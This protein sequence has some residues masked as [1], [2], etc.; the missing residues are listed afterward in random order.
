MTVHLGLV[1]KFSSHTVDPVIRDRFFHYLSRRSTNVDQ[2]RHA[3]SLLLTLLR[4]TDDSVVFIMRSSKE[5][6][7]NEPLHHPS[8]LI[9]VL[10]LGAH[11]LFP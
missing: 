9:H 6:S 11:D 7:S 2:L 8:A 4:T 5:V 10:S 3:R 1:L